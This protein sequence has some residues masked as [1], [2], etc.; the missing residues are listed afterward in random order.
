MSINIIVVVV[1]HRH[2][3]LDPIYTTQ[4]VHNQDFIIVSFTA[5]FR[6]NSWNICF[7]IDLPCM[8]ENKSLEKHHQIYIVIKYT[9]IHIEV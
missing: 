1:N 7:L 2:K 8:I 4:Y 9:Y 3:L 6:Y 5:Y